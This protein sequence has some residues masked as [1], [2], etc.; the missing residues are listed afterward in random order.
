M[1]NRKDM[2]NAVAEATGKTKKDSKVL[3]ESIISVLKSTL[4]AGE[5]V[6]IVNFGT[7]KIVARKARKGRNPRT[8]EAL[9]IPAK[10]VVRFKVGKSLAGSVNE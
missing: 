2:I 10:N 6:K 4:S 5:D 9:D 3:V 7:F 1:A 8:G